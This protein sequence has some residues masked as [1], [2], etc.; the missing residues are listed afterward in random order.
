MAQNEFEKITKEIDSEI[1]A[2]KEYYKKNISQ[3]NTVQT[4]TRVSFTP[5][6]GTFKS[7]WLNIAYP[8]NRLPILSV[9]LDLNDYKIQG[10]T[11]YW[12]LSWYPDLDNNR[13]RVLVSLSDIE[14]SM[15]G[16]TWSVDVII[17]STGTLTITE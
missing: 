2:L 15:W 1:S 16:S 8:P 9:A 10:T 11:A 14:Q 13:F 6:S 7:K 4:S 17:T 5:T 12:R 3:F